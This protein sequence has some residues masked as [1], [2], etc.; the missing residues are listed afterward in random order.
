MKLADRPVDSWLH[1]LPRDL[2]PVPVEMVATG[3][4]ALA[5]AGAH[6][7]RTL[8]A[9]GGDPERVAWAAEVAR[10]AGAQHIGAFVNVVA[11]PDLAIARQLSVGGLTTFA[12]FSAMDGI[13]R[14]PID[15]ASGRVL[16]DV[17]DSYDMRQHT[18]ASS[19]QAARLTPEF[20][21]R[22]GIVGPPDNCGHRLRELAA[23]GIDRFVVVGPS[24]DS[25][26][27]QALAAMQTFTREV[28][29][30]LKETTV[31]VP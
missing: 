7:D 1:W 30:A 27:E 16:H 4:K 3:P 29:P 12:R 13:V 15:E 2:Q 5:V 17:H 21:D 14:T 6:S 28:L 22:F 19:P 26:R 20:I 10:A 25:D 9:V 31:H 18:R 23:I 8:L 24:I 11:H